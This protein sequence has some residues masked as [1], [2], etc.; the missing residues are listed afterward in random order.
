MAPDE[1]L[2]M[3]ELALLVFDIE[4]FVRFITGAISVPFEKEAPFILWTIC[5]CTGP[6]LRPQLFIIAMG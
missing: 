6:P 5:C 2:A 3:A 4:L 1:L